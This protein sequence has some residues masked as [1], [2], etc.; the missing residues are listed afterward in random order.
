MESAAAD[1]PCPANEEVSKRQMKG[2]WG[3]GR[4]PKGVSCFVARGQFREDSLASRYGVRREIFFLN[5]EDGYF[6]CQVNESTDVLQLFQLS[7]LCNGVPDCFM[8]SDELAQ[9]LKCT[10]NCLYTTGRRC[11]NG[12]CLDSQCHCNDGF[13]GKGCE[14]PDEN[15]CK[16]RPCDVFARCTNTMG[17]FYCSCYPGYEGDGFTCQGRLPHHAP[18]NRIPLS[19]ERD[20]ACLPYQPVINPERASLV[21]E[22][23]PRPRYEGQMVGPCTQCPEALCF[24]RN[25]PNA[26]VYGRETLSV[27][28][29][30]LLPVGCCLSAVTV[31]V[32]RSP[33]ED[34]GRTPGGPR[35]VEAGGEAVE[36]YAGRRPFAHWEQIQF[37][38]V[39]AISTSVRSP[40]LLR[41]V[42]QTPNA[43]I[44]RLIISANACLASAAKGTWNAW[45]ADLNECDSRDACG[46]GAV[47]QNE[48]GGYRCG[49]PAGYTG[50]PYRAGCT[51]IDECRGNP[52]GQGAAC[53]NTPGSFQ[54]RCPDGFQGNPQLG[55][56]DV[57]ECANETTP[58]CGPGATCE[59]TPGG[60][61]CTCTG[62]WT[63]SGEGCVDV[64]E[65]ESGLACGVN[66]E[67]R[68][69]PGSYRCVCPPGFTGLP[70][71]FCNNVDECSADTDDCPANSHCKD[72]VGSYACVCD[73]GFALQLA[74][75]ESKALCVDIDECAVLD[76][77]C[78]RNAVCQNA[79]PGYTCTCKQGYDPAPRPDIACE[80][81]SV[82]TICVSNFDCVNNAECTDGTCRCRGGFLTQGA[83]C[84]DFR[85][86]RDRIRKDEMFDPI[87]FSRA[88]VNECEEANVC[89]AHAL[90]VNQPGSYACKCETGY[91]GDP[92]THPCKGKSFLFRFFSLTNAHVDECLSLQ[93][94]CGINAKC[95]NLPGG[96]YCECPS[97]LVGDPTVTC[98]SP[99]DGVDCGPHA[100]CKP[101]G[102]EALCICDDGWSYDPARIDAGCMDINECNPRIGPSGMCGENAICTNTLGSYSCQCPPGFSGNPYTRCLDVNE[103]T[104]PGA[105]GKGA[106]CQNSLGS[107]ECACPAGTVPEPDPHTACVDHI[108]CKGDGDC[109]GNAICDATRQCLCPTPN[110]GQDCRHPCEDI[111][112]GPN[113]ECML[114]NG[115]P[116]CMCSNGYSGSTNEV[117]G[118]VDVNECLANPCAPNALC[119]NGPGTFSCECPNGYEG[120]P[121]KKECRKVKA[122][123]CSGEKPCPIG[124]ECVAEE[125]TGNNVCVYINECLE[126]R[127]KPA[128][129]FN[130]LC[131]NLPGSYVCECPPGYVGNPFAS[132][133]ECNSIECSCL[134]P[135]KFIDGSCVLTNCSTRNPCP[136]GA[137]CVQLT[138]GL[139]YCACPKGYQT[140]PDGTCQDINECRFSNGQRVCGFGADCVNLPGSYE[141]LCPPGSRGDPYQGVCSLAARIECQR[142]T[143][144]GANERCVQP[145]ECICP[146]P[147]FVDTTDGNKC[148]SPCE[149]FRCGLNAKCTPSDPPRCMCRP[150]FTGDPLRGC[151]DMNEC[152]TES[153]C[154]KGA[155]CI[156]EVGGFKCQ[157]PPGTT[158][159][160]ITHGCTGMATSACQQDSDCGPNLA[161]KSGDCVNP[162]SL[163]PCGDNAYCTVEDSAAWCR[164]LPGFKEGRNGACASICHDVLCGDNA[165][166]IVTPDGPTCAC[167]EGYSGNP[168][169]GGAC[170]ADVCDAGNRCR[171]PLMCIQGRCKERCSGVVCGVGAKCDKNTN[172]CI[173][174][175]FFIGNPDLLCVPPVLPPICSPP[176]GDNAHCEYGFPNKCV[177]NAGT[178][179][180]PYSSCGAQERTCA[181]TQCGKNAQC[182][183]DVNECMGNAC[184]MNAI[185][186][187]TIGSYDCRCQAGFTGNPFMMCMPV[188]DIPRGTCGP[189]NPC[190][191][192]FVC[193]KNLC[194]DRCSNIIC[195]QN[196]ICSDGK[197]VCLPGFSGS[198]ADRNS[199]CRA[200]ECDNDLDCPSSQI[201]FS[202][203]VGA[204]KCTDACRKVQCGPNAVCVAENHRSACICLNGFAGNPSDLKI[205][206]TPLQRSECSDDDDCPGNTV[207]QVNAQGFPACVDPCQNLFCGQNEVCLLREAVP[208]C[209]CI[210]TYARNPVSG[211]CEK[212]SIPE[213][214][215]DADCPLHGSCRPDGLG[216]LKC[217]DVCSYVTCPQFSRCVAQNHRGV[218]GC[219][220]GYAGNPNSREG[221][222]PQ[223]QDQ[224]QSDTQCPETQVCREENAIRRCLPV[225]QFVQCGPGSVCVANN[226]EGQCQ[227]PPGK[228][229]GDPNDLRSG[230]QAVSC[231]MN[232]DCPKDQA[233]N[234]LDYACYDVCRDA[235][236]SNAICVAANHAPQCSCRPGFRPNVSPEIGCLPLN[237]CDSAPC[238]SSAQCV[239]APNGFACQCPQGAIGDPYVGGCR[240]GGDYCTTNADC[241]PDSACTKGVCRNPCEGEP[242]G[243]NAVCSVKDRSALC[244]C[245]SGFGVVV[246]GAGLQHCRRIVSGCQA[247]GDCGGDVCIQGMCRIVCGSDGDC[248]QGER[249]LNKLC[250]SPCLGHAQCPEKQACLR[251]FCAAGCRNNADC[252]REQAC[253]NSKCTDPC[254]RPGACGPNA[255]CRVITHSAQCY[256]PDGF[257]G[258]PYPQQGCVRTP[259]DCSTPAQCPPRFICQAN[260]CRPPCASASECAA[261]ERCE[262]GMCLK[263][264]Y[265]DNNC[266]QGEVCVEGMC[267]PGCRSASD[268]RQNEVCMSNQCRCGTGFVYGLVGCEDIDECTNSP[269]HPSAICVNLPG[270]FKCTCPQGTVGDPNQEGCHP[271]H[272][273]KSDD[274]CPESLSCQLNGQEILKC[275]NPCTLTACGPNA[276]CIVQKHLAF[277]QCRPGHMGSP[278][279]VS[280][281]CFRVECIYNEDCPADKLCDRLSNRCIDVCAQVDCGRGTCR[282]ENHGPVCV[283]QAGYFVLGD[284]CVDIDECKENPCHPSGICQN[285][286]GSH[287]CV[288]PEGLVGDPYLGGCLR[289]GEC[290]TEAQCPPN[291]ICVNNRCQNPCEQPNACGRGAQC[292][293]INRQAVCRC[294]V[295]TTGNP[296]IQCTTLECIQSDDCGNNQACV[297]NQC[298]DP[299]GIPGVCGRDTECRAGNHQAGCTCSPGFTGDPLLGCSPIIQCLGDG[300]CPTGEVCSNGVCT[301]TCTSARD[302]LSDQLCID[303]RCTPRCQNDA[304]CS[305]F[306]TCQNGICVVVSRCRS[307]NDCAGREACRQ[308]AVGQAECQDVCDGLVLCGRNAECV[309][310]NHAPS[311]QC[312]AG[313]FGNPQDDKIGCERKQCDK[314]DDC[315]QSSDVCHE[316]KCKAACRV[317]NPCGEGAQCVS[318]NHDAACRCPEGFTGD[319]RVR[320]RQ[321]DYCA[322]EPCGLGAECQNARRGTYI[323]RCPEG[324]VGDP[325]AEGCEEPVACRK[326]GDCPLTARCIMVRNRPKCQDVCEGVRCGPN[327][328]CKPVNHAA[329][330]T[331]IDGYTGSGD[332]L[333]IGCTPIQVRCNSNQDCSSGTICDGGYCRPPCGSDDECSASEACVRGQCTNLCDTDSACGLNALCEMRGHGKHCT[334][335]V[336]FEGEPAVECIRTPTPCQS[337]EQ[338]PFGSTCQYGVCMPG[339]QGD[340]ECALNEKCVNGNCI[341][342][343]RVDN[344]CFLGHICLNNMCLIGCRANED[345]GSSEA[346]LNNRC[347][348]PCDA[349]AAC[350][351]NAL[352]SVVG[353]RAQ[354]SCP[355]RFIPNPTPNVACVREPTPCVTNNDCPAGV[356]CT[357][358]VCRPI[359]SSVQNCLANEKCDEGV[360]K[361]ICRR[362]GDCRNGEICQGL[363]CVVGC[364]ADNECPSHQACINNKC[365]DPCDSSTACGTNAACSVRD[366]QVSCVCPPPLQGD[367][368]LSC[369]QPPR[370][371]KADGDCPD[372]QTCVQGLCRPKCSSDQSC[373][374]NERCVGGVCKSI[375]NSDDQCEEG[376][377]CDGRLCR[378]G[379]R[380]DAQCELQKACIDRVC[381]NP[382]E[383]AAACGECALCQVANHS[384]QCTCPAEMVGN[385]SVLCQRPPK[386]C[387]GD[388]GCGRGGVCRDGFCTNACRGDDGCSCG[389]TCVQN[390]CH[391]KCSNTN[392]CSRSH[393]CRDGICVS[394]C[395]SDNDCPND[396][397]CAKS[398]CTN[399]CAERK[400]C[401]KGAQCLASDHQAVCLCPNGFVGDP[402]AL[403]EKVECLEDRNCEDSKYCREGSCVNPCLQEGACGLNAQCRVDDRRAVCQCPPG[404]AGNP[405]VECQRDVNECL[406]NPCGTN[407]ICTDTPNSFTCECEPGCQGDPYSGCI[408]QGPQIDP[409]RTVY[410]GV[411]AR[412]Q[413]VD[414]GP[415]CYCPP[416]HPLGDPNRECKVERIDLDCRQSGCGV[417]AQCVRSGENYM[418]RCPGGTTGDPLEKCDSP[419]ELPFPRPRRLPAGDRLRS[420][421]ERSRKRDAAARVPDASGRKRRSHS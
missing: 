53:V 315:R 307:D 286:P 357:G 52:C 308:N 409:C 419:G 191:Q 267:Q 326:D 365:I 149:R 168:F 24:R 152:A 218:C 243:R 259:T 6:G 178:S 48:V 393:L 399:P 229:A 317:Q 241:P 198:P 346:C 246:T 356:V 93:H 64:D 29:S 91:L 34:P 87:A 329:T 377:I 154:A 379:C 349:G 228:Y 342:T 109:P 81:I 161:C 220:P 49:C 299:C 227:C 416:S 176:C 358:S 297:E 16:Y 179:G 10:S 412:C 162:C 372:D 310:K 390:V 42:C 90:C 118:C 245:R 21:P 43:A 388:R 148:K 4:G 108:S 141:C 294:P 138:G 184:G 305:T 123:G 281:G 157:C 155:V 150:G 369:R 345:C 289:P 352:C 242:C 254:G 70:D 22:E 284:A 181:T 296:S 35:P 62:G 58:A 100:Q 340:N 269:C 280:V 173:C 80:Q 277:C 214:S 238:H 293:A 250:M 370:G 139:T 350:G 74:R 96:F 159:D 172:K 82:R 275:M 351:P 127:D 411:N 125:F 325:Y 380:S 219:L 167:L 408:C 332:D 99:C 104:Q 142:D 330:C 244:T 174:L 410:C 188:E 170:G 260:K 209:E 320:C 233:C 71:V 204:R 1:S 415:K 418:C 256:C 395:R 182:K 135:S 339:C 102:L 262:N 276:D 89:G 354:C 9:E 92:P 302:C 290:R 38:L 203:P 160:A 205:G 331:C 298:V 180:N 236:G 226:H 140:L 31:A 208:V 46:P 33:R 396:Q 3:E 163:L 95:F 397:A 337:Q 20:I 362:D 341:L 144:C 151:A 322:A 192:G 279:D 381:R 361:P 202:Q 407:A 323:C 278:A 37:Q 417:G 86:W 304:D 392:D 27:V 30:R 117:A 406:G 15:E 50:E 45:C 383:S 84:I 132:C 61:T 235:C 221:C 251:G 5:Q 18:E 57:D 175:P 343:C 63:G 223:P 165:E 378:T 386:A 215:R 60:F 55:C 389:E 7:K 300:Q 200:H 234:R 121:Y 237:P 206:C 265:T 344:D 103:C 249:C 156:N 283:C 54:C 252:G 114:I 318:E 217:I 363:L 133:Q 384:P 25:E 311:C 347:V 194:V 185:C 405:R 11:V 120:D 327:S 44:C 197:C 129:G 78:G 72:T 335:P 398:K 51:D 158:G 193:E 112:C 8:G 69:T 334:C 421:P 85:E 375:C 348:N 26:T 137:E 376:E 295:Q 2:A 105:C 231:I 303:G 94:P 136:G 88:D 212:P 186:I 40:N 169:P 239:A 271:P 264:C 270:T 359:C 324:T 404:F 115:R 195:G 360:C 97:P 187:N 247:D 266:L 403:C 66:A 201:C 306:Q 321:I 23:S 76:E 355:E 28:A 274:D 65:C 107:F 312:R 288:C 336:G 400:P 68:N 382:C 73:S 282:A 374:D 111:Y 13:G 119:R 145:G 253:I 414:G 67:C 32:P 367:P 263:V 291:A 222:V 183:T 124:E 116:R 401:G 207:C 128:C 122:P 353:H 166:C 230:C 225:C 126:F 113:A 75:S 211:K 338:C 232:S 391:K 171:P 316:F 196:A 210:P 328:L 309:P 255:L 143:D 385:P 387:T 371:C 420:G 313:F 413:V 402:F 216:V 373:L 12:A 394:G 101:Q 314:N 368:M 190:P 79:V 189:G 268:C 213:C 164:C 106:V 366:H 83:T 19:S 17:S 47:C 287:K 199:G 177:C 147:F 258:S 301:S 272:E 98:M 146:P 134:P 56:A 292:T 333:N 59:N 285:L 319:A 36:V 41:N 248:A 273:C 224:C 130:A 364:R 14:M 240:R 110:I 153:P 77:P 39:A 261:G 131:K 257:E